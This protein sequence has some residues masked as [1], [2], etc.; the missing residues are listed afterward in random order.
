M[1][2]ATH[3]LRTT[4]KARDALH[5]Q[6]QAILRNDNSDISSIWI[7]G[8]LAYAWRS[9]S[10]NSFWRSITLIL[11]CVLHLL[12]FGAAGILASRMTTTDDEVLISKNPYCGRWDLN[13]TMGQVNIIT[14][15]T[16]TMQAS[17]E[18]VQN[19]LAESQSLPECHIFK[20]VQ[21]NWTSSEDAPCPFGDLCLGQPNSSLYMD[22]GLLDSRDDFGINSQHF[23]RVQWRK[24]ATC[25]PITTSGYTQQGVSFIDY[26]YKNIPGRQTINYTALFYGPDYNMLSA[27]GL[28]D[29][30]ISNATYVFTNFQT[31]MIPYSDYTEPPYYLQFVSQLKVYKT[32]ANVIQN[33]AN[34]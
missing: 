10:P 27:A 11:L 5:H 1:R 16:T 2:F 19:C 17:G 9:R 6:Q 24:R 33:S 25:M 15:G 12:A 31:E 14:Y 22:T 23:D 29:P 7:L 20:K 32:S 3:Q 21:L 28:T 34:R 4:T 18:Y 13:T 26:T 30:A 8:W